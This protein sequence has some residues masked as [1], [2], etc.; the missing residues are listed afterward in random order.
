MLTTDHEPGTAA[1]LSSDP[2]CWCGVD[3]P[4]RFTY[5]AVERGWHD[6]LADADAPPARRP[7]RG[8]K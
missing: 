5:R 2:L 4:P 1:R 6:R 8:R 7:H 3:H